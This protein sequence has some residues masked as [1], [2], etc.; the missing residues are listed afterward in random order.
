M[1]TVTAYANGSTQSL[2]HDA[3]GQLIAVTTT[4]PARK[5]TTPTSGSG[6]IVN[7]KA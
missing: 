7:T 3:H 2:V 5:T 4:P 6:F 1:T